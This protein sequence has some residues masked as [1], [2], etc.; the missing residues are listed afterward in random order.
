[1]G[2]PYMNRTL[3]YLLLTGIAISLIL[4]FSGYPEAG[5]MALILTPHLPQLCLCTVFA[6]LEN[7]TF[8]YFRYFH[9]GNHFVYVNDRCRID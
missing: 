5:A 3:E 1:M 4:I 8:F 9:C 6:L 7:L 2:S